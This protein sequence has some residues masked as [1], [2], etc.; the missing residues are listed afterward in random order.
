MRMIDRLHE[1]SGFTRNEL[2]VIL[3]L[4]GTLAI[5]AG[6][7]WY[8][9]SLRPVPA[10]PFNY[11]AM[12]REFAERSR[13]STPSRADPAPR[14]TPPPPGALININTAPRAEL[15]RLPGIGEKYA[16]RIIRYRREHGPFA[17]PEA[18]D[19]VQGI[20]RKTVERLRPFICVR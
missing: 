1:T 6:I 20:G 19:A 5:G 7:R 14:R 10:T 16:D 18:L 12:D 13:T 11:G 17:T 4:A 2:K 3:F 8:V 15:M 9:T